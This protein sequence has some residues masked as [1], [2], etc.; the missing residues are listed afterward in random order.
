M[1]TYSETGLV[2]ARVVFPREQLSMTA[3]AISRPRDAREMTMTLWDLVLWA[4]VA[5]PVAFIVMAFVY[6]DSE[7]HDTFQ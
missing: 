6:A 5:I 2:A 7:L 3:R 4:A 1:A